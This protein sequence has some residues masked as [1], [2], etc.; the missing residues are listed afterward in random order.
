[1]PSIRFVV[2]GQYS[3]KDV[4]RLLGEP[5]ESLGGIWANGL[6]PRTDDFLIFCNIG[7]AGRT[8]HTYDNHWIGD[9]LHW[10]GTKS[11]DTSKGVYKRLVT[12]GCPI[13]LF[14]RYQDRGTYTY[15]GQAVPTQIVRSHPAIILWEFG[16]TMER[17]PETLPEEIVGSPSFVDGVARQ[18]T[19]NSFERNPA[20]RAACIAAHGVRCRVCDF[21]FESVYGEIGR[22]YVHVHHV[23]PLAEVRS[24]HDIDPTTDLVPVCPNCHAMIHRYPSA[25]SVDALKLM[26]QDQARSARV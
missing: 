10:S 9:R 18:I 22:G 8:G 25:I 1:L 16:N 12:G 20:A 6:V 19:V 21:D 13:Y 7:L 26:V 5:D 23:R 17:R 24:A 4:K 15:A 14:Y 2:N 11:S 3:R